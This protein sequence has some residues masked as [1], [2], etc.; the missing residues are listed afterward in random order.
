MSKVDN[1]FRSRF[2]QNYH[3]NSEMTSKISIWL[4]NYI[5]FRN[6]SDGGNC[7]RNTFT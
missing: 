5:K 1:Q 3:I 4:Q 2:S 7:E 6:D